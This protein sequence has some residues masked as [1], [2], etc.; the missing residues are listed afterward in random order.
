MMTYVNFIGTTKQ[1][2]TAD[3]QKIKRTESKHTTTRNHQFTRNAAREGKKR[4][5]LKKR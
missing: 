4:R 5:L 3:S 2:S 1:K